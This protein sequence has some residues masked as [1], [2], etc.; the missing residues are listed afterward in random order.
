[1]RHLHAVHNK[2]NTGETLLWRSD[3]NSELCL[4]CHDKGITRR[5][6]RLCRNPRSVRMRCA[7]GNGFDPFPP[8]IFRPASGMCVPTR[9]WPEGD[10][11]APLCD[12]AVSPW[13]YRCRE[14]NGA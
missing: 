13:H 5:R 6:W 9:S 8:R 12:N 14:E 10:L 2:G 1:M 11:R 7:R 3:V 4:T